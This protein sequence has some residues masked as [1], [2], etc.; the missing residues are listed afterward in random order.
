MDETGGEAVTEYE[1][2]KNKKTKGL[3]PVNP[4][5]KL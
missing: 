2:S 1:K 3:F 4:Y 5:Q